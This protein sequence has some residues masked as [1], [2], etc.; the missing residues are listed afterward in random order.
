MVRHSSAERDSY[1]EGASAIQNARK[2]IL[3]GSVFNRHPPDGRWARSEP[4]LVSGSWQDRRSSPGRQEIAV[5]PPES[6]AEHIDEEAR[7]AVGGEIVNQR[8]L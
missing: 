1:T 6:Q 8:K 2:T 3:Q 7:S 5:D 4:A